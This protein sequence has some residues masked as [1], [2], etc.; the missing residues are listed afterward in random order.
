MSDAPSLVYTHK[1]AMRL[2]RRIVDTVLATSLLVVTAPVLFV[3]MLAIVLEDGRP[4]LFHQRRVGRFER[5]FTMHKLR[6]LRVDQ[7]VDRATPT[8][9]RDPRI[10]SVGRILRKTSIDELPQLVNVIRGEMSIVGP[11][12]DMPV[13][14]ERYANW[15]RMRHLVSPGITCIWQTTH[16]SDVPLQ[17]PE[18][19]AL[20]LDYIKRAS[21]ALDTMLLAR[22]VLAVVSSKGAY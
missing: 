9:S 14:M 10:T 5:L 4:V 7:C 2:L 17:R 3:A 12:P 22:T 6:T 18:A 15:Q 11:R 19:S 21:P 1:P 8:T 16:R 13:M 20:D